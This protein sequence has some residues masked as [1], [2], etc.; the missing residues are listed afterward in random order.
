MCY[1]SA[2]EGLAT[3]VFVYYPEAENDSMKTSSTRLYLN[4]LMAAPLAERVGTAWGHVDRMSLVSALLKDPN[5]TKER[6]AEFYVGSAIETED[7][8]A[9]GI[10]A[11]KVLLQLLLDNNLKECPL[12]LTG[13]PIFDS[14]EW[15]H[16]TQREDSDGPFLDIEWGVDHASD[17]RDDDDNL[18]LNIDLWDLNVIVHPLYS[19]G[20]NLCPSA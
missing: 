4:G 6:A 8:R 12:V 19:E 2:K 15:L 7:D 1:E 10:A 13:Y 3:L 11:T 5:T 9:K 14:G 16:L 17:M 18:M 20:E